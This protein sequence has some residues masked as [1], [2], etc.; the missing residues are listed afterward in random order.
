MESPNVPSTITSQVIWFN[1]HIKIDDKSLCNNSLANQGITHV[2]QFFNENGVAKAWLDIKSQF[3]FSNKQ[4]YFWIQLINK[5]P[6][7]WKEE[8]LRNNCI[9]DAL[10]VYDH[11][12]IKKKSNIFFR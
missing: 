7:S 12:L 9:P 4:H 8:L 5:T 11:H 6:K 1:K 2:G 3:N 10:S